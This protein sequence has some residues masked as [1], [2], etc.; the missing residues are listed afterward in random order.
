[1]IEVHQGGPTLFAHDLN[2]ANAGVDG[3]E[4]STAIATEPQTAT[5]VV[6]GNIRGGPKEVLA[7][8]QILDPIPVH[9]SNVQGKDRRELCFPGKR[10]RLEAGASI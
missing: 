6:A 10:H 8:K 2:P 5:A 1:M 3:S 7:A 9:I 4:G